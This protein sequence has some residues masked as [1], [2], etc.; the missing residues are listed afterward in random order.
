[1]GEE[2][3]LTIET[4]ADREN[5]QVHV[6]I[7][8]TGPGIPEDVQQRIFGLHFTTKQGRVQFGLGMGLS[9][10]RQIV[11]RH[12]GSIEL[13]SRP[14]R[15]CFKVILPVRQPVGGETARADLTPQNP[16]QDE[17]QARQRNTQH[18]GLS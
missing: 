14:G 7:I 5:E 16:T 12:G 8:D 1:M 2:G 6:S 10:C 4:G 13:D 17:P 9:I 3:T 18:G 11:T 15:T